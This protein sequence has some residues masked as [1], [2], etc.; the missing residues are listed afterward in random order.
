MKRKTRWPGRLGEQRGGL[1]QERR[2]QGQPN[3][4]RNHHGQQGHFSFNLLLGPAQLG[5]NDHT[6]MNKMKEF[7]W[8]NYWMFTSGKLKACPEA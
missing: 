6:E 1:V 8:C 3:L 2:K 7:H 4:Q 5:L